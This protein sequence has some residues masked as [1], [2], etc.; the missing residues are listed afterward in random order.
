M[1]YLQ[2]WQFVRISKLQDGRNRQ[3]QALKD[4]TRSNNQ[5]D[6][7]FLEQVTWIHLLTPSEGFSE[8]KGDK[9]HFNIISLL[10]M[11]YKGPY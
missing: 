4:T 6:V 11:T 10:S 2:D 3:H 8:N 7:G 1:V 9:Q 5:R